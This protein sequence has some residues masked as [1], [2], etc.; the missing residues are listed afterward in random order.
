MRNAG[1]QRGEERREEGAGEW[2]RISSMCCY[3]M[4]ATRV[5]FRSNTQRDKRTKMAKEASKAAAEGS[6]R[7]EERGPEIRCK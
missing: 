4:A 6:E 2:Q 3:T 7:E 1:E 5:E